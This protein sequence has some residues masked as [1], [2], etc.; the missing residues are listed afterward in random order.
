MGLKAKVLI[1]KGEYVPDNF[2]LGIVEKKLNSAA[3]RFGAI[4]D[5]FPWTIS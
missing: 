4:F 3:C 1:D 5:G 2:I